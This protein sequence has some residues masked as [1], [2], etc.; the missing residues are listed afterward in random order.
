MFL[1]FVT[2]FTYSIF[3]PWE[4]IIALKCIYYNVNPQVLLHVNNL[5][6]Q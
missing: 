3:P 4:I 6:V 5:N 1:T 2:S